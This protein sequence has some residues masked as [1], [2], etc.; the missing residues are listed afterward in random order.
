MYVTPLV[1]EKL[2][3]CFEEHAEHFL[4]CTG[5]HLN[6]VKYSD[7]QLQKICLDMKSMLCVAKTS[8]DNC[9]EDGE[10]L[11]KTLE[12]SVDDSY[13]ELCKRELTDASGG[14]F[15]NYWVLASSVFIAFLYSHRVK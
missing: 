6:K 1:Y 10:A 3:P 4:E 13:H 15:F 12:F 2:S 8:R 7:P 5:E 9:G 14:V 11:A